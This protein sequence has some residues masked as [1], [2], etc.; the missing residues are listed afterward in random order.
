ME[1]MEVIKTGILSVSAFAGS[2]AV[3]WGINQYRLTKLT[4]RRLG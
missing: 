4:G 2:G 3:I 1:I